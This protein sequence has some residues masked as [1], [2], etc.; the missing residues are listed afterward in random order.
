MKFCIRVFRITEKDNGYITPYQLCAE[1][2]SLS[3]G[4]ASGASPRWYPFIGCNSILHKRTVKYGSQW[5]AISEMAK[6]YSTNVLGLKMGNERVVVVY[7]EKNIQQVSNDKVFDARPDNFFL[8]LRSFGRRCGIT[9]VDGPLWREHK[10]FTFKYLRNIGYGKELMHEDIK[11][12]LKNILNFINNSNG[13]PINIKIMVAMSAMNILWKYVAGE[14]IKDSQLRKI[15]ELLSARSKIFTMAGGWLNQWPF[16]RFIA[17]EWSGYAVIKKMN[18]QIHD[19][20]IESIEKHKKKSVKGKD[21]IYAFLDEMHKNK[22]TYTED[23]LTGTCLDFLI[24][25]AQ[26]IG[27]SFDF[28]IL[29]ALRNADIQ[30]KMYQEI[31]SVLGDE[32]Y[33]WPDIKRLVYT[34]AFVCEVQRYYTIAVFSG[35]RRTLA[36]S[37]LDGYTI[38]SGTTILVSLGDL[39]TDPELWDEPT[40]FEPER[41]IDANGRLKSSTHSYPFGLGRRRCPGEPLAKPFLL[42]SL[43]AILQKYRIESS[44]G[45]LPSDE[46]H[47][48]ML[49]EPRPFTARFVKRKLSQ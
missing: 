29:A 34:T 15:I 44:N 17:P 3:A 11:Y 22:A 19:I 30:E 37:I 35:A 32:D 12:N 8:R 39:H 1:G 13:N 48:G 33:N 46:P 38:P 25:G 45:V 6:E 43:V 42:T 9:F 14:H 31:I 40:K 28:M 16:L 21:F 7:G 18:E 24:A 20:I 47:I 26:T 5:K 4:K 27:S 49:A 10:L 23:Q 41:F 2:S 36:D